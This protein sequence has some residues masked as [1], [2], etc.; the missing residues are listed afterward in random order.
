MAAKCIKYDPMD[1]VTKVE[2]SR[3]IGIAEPKLPVSRPSGDALEMVS[4]GLGGRFN[5]SND[6][7]GHDLSFQISLGLAQAYDR[8]NIVDEIV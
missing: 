1:P 2:N 3:S 7:T 6:R 4:D 5:H 8:G